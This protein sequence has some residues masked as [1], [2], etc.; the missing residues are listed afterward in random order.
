MAS[1]S[2]ISES[3]LECS[4]L[5]GCQPWDRQ[6]NFSHFSFGEDV[7]F[8]KS[9]LIPVLDKEC[10]LVNKMLDIIILGSFHKIVSKHEQ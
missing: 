8:L 4:P 1:N 5:V 9:Y 7:H 3:C 2:K 10:T 6:A